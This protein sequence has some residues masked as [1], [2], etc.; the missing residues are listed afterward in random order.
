VRVR[1]TWNNFGAHIFFLSSFFL[2]TFDGDN[3]FDF[4]I[5]WMDDKRSKKKTR[6]AHRVFFWWLPSLEFIGYY[7]QRSLSVTLHFL[8]S[9]LAFFV[10]L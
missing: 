9:A 1:A 8:T 7:P 4:D 5:I 2:L 3:V 6:S 10:R